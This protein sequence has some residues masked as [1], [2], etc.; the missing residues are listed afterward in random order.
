MRAAEA[1]LARELGQQAIRVRLGA[2]V[3]ITAIFKQTLGIDTL[4]LDYNLPDEDVHAPNEFF[5]LKSIQEGA[6]AWTHL[7]AELG[8]C[9]PASVHRTTQ[10]N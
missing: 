2:T 4:M 7:L 1:V 3:P 8:R 10:A 6:R 5:R 9:A